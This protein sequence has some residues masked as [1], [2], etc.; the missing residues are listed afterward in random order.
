MSADAS[1][2]ACGSVK[3]SLF[4]VRYVPVLCSP[5]PRKCL[6]FAKNFFG[7]EFLMGASELSLLIQYRVKSLSDE[8]FD[9]QEGPSFVIGHV[10]II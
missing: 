3:V 9:F 10:I 5:V 7:S 4:I 6:M 1:A 8:L 2:W